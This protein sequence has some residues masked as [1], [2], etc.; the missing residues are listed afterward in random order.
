MGEDARER[1]ELRAPLD[2]EPR[3]VTVAESR[4]PVLR[5]TAVA[6]AVL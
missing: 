3:T 1:A 4:A 5:A 2:A 6:A